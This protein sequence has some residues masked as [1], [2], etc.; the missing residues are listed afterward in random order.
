MEQKKGFTLLELLVVGGVIG[1][2]SVVV[3]QIF[4]ST[5]H[6]NTK[7]EIMKEVKQSG[8]DSLDIMK[9]MIQNAK[10]VSS[11]CIDVGIYPKPIFT[12]LTIVGFDTQET[13][14][15]C[16]DDATTASSRIVSI[17][18]SNVFITSQNVTLSDS[19]GQTGCI[20]NPLTFTCTSVGGVPSEITFSFHL[21]QKQIAPSN[22]EQSSELFQTTVYLRNTK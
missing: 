22:Y 2:I 18:A 8:N 12:S 3:A 10:T 4:F 21:R 16:F 7:T 19:L 9:R 1:F 13:T 6:I 11:S 15:S 17:S 20:N 5:I 14:F